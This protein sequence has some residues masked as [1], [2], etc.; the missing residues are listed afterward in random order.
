MC[1]GGGGGEG[2]GVVGGWEV[3]GRLLGF[4]GC[5]L[6]QAGIEQKEISLTHHRNHESPP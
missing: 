1:G 3:R 4:C 5:H 2:G 6:T